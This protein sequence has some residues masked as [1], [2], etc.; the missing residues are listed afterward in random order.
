MR[1]PTEDPPEAAT[2][3]QVDE[4]RMRAPGTA[5]TIAVVLLLAASAVGSAVIAHVVVRDQERRLL[6]ERAAEAGL[7][8]GSSFSS[9]QST[10]AS[11]GTIALSTSS[12]PDAFVKAAAPQAT[13]AS[14]GV[15]LVGSSPNGPVVLAAAGRAFAAGD[16]FTGP[17]A[18]AVATAL[19]SRGLV[20]TTVLGRTRTT[21]EVG[22]VLGPPQAPPGQVVYF[23]FGLPTVVTS[24]PGNAFSELDAAVFAVPRPDPRQLLLGTRGG[25][26]SGSVARQVVRIGNSKWLI[27]VSAKTP[28]VGSLAPAIPWVLLVLGLMAAVLIGTVIHVVTRRR[29]YALALVDERTAA[30]RE[31]LAELEAAQSRLVRQERLA[32]VGQLAS[33]VGHELRNPLGVITNSLYLIRTATSATAD[34]RLRRHLATAEREVSAATVIVADLLDFARARDP[35]IHAVDIVALVDEVVEVVPPPEG[36]TVRWQ[37]PADLPP[38]AADRDQLRQ[39]L[40]NLVSNGYDAMPDG[41]SLHVEAA[42]HG[43]VVSLR[44]SDQGVGID[45]ETRRRLFEPFFTTKARGTGLGLAVSERIVN[46]HHGTITV[47]TAPGSG[48]T[49]TVSIPASLDRIPAADTAALGEGRR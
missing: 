25:L 6:R 36:I 21:S 47:D 19:H 29:D 13:S 27:A 26:P 4:K 23:E 10:L 2:A 17:R 12:S 34:E 39:V 8:V 33:A 3:V 7:V 16:H 41:G 5:L 1:T 31:S 24:I 14:G 43:G 22:M 11:L 20:S 9:V 46:A 28:L 44:V 37:A 42:A 32:A 35:I 30:L 40:I 45:P 15:A 38:A 49:F 18:D 48:S